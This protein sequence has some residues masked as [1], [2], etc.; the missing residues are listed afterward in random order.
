[1]NVLILLEIQ[2]KTLTSKCVVQ[3]FMRGLASGIFYSLRKYQ[4]D[5]NI[6]GPGSFPWGQLIWCDY[7]KITC[8]ELDW[9]WKFHQAPFILSKVF[10]VFNPDTHTL[11]SIYRQLNILCPFGYLLLHNIH[12]AHS[13]GEGKRNYNI[14]TNLYTL[15]LTNNCVGALSEYLKLFW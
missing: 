7:S 11:P 1:M 15:K 5:P 3:F 6:Y 10:Q 14:Q 4:Y 8:R 9:S 13:I 2:S 12:L